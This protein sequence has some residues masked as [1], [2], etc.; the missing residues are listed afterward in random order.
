MDWRSRVISDP[1]ILLGK[2]IIKG[3][4]ISVDLI[5]RWLASGWSAD[6]II[7]AYPNITREDVFAALMFAA[8][9]ISGVLK[10]PGNK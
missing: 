6:K 7:E 10:T 2:P 8:D 5:L 9:T 1:A 4:R 3:T